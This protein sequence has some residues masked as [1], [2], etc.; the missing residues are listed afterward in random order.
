MP[1]NTA[2][3]LYR[4]HFCRA[5]E[6][7]ADR[8]LPAIGKRFVKTFPAI[9]FMAVVFA[10]RIA[11]GNGRFLLSAPALDDSRSQCVTAEM[12]QRISG[13][14]QAQNANAVG[15]RNDGENVLVSQCREA[16]IPAAGPSVLAWYE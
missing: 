10:D 9:I 2:F 15:A 14:Q 8:Q 16:W 6:V 13:K 5:G 11:A 1:S 7:K 12:R 4:R 3:S